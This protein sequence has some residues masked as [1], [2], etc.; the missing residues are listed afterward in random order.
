MR[1]GRVLVDVYVKGAV[2][3]RAAALRGEGMRV[4]ALSARAPQRMVEGW[5]PLSALDD[6]AAL[7]GTR[8]VVPVYPGILST[9]SVLSEG[10]A[11]GEA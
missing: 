5:L 9:G 3:D 8:A 11:S 10:D 2:R 6:V 4:E 1:D 7:D